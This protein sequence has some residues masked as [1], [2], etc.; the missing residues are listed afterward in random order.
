MLSLTGLHLPVGGFVWISGVAMHLFDCLCV[1]VCKL[2][3]VAA[4]THAGS[5]DTDTEHARKLR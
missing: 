2:G 4:P 5:I 1:G 3:G